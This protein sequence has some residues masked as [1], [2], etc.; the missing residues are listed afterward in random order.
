MPVIKVV[1]KQSNHKRKVPFSFK[2]KGSKVSKKVINPSVCVQLTGTDDQKLD[3]AEGQF[4]KL[5][6]IS[7]HGKGFV[8]VAFNGTS[9]TKSSYPTFTG[10]GHSINMNK[11]DLSKLVFNGSSTGSSYTVCYEVC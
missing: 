9:P 5:C 2:Q 3:V 1:R 10:A 11:V 6:Y 7:E 4:G 8:R